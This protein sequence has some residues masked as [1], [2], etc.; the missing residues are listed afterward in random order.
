MQCFRGDLI[1]NLDGRDIGGKPG[2]PR[3]PEPLERTR[4]YALLK[5][6]QD[7]PPEQACVNLYLRARVASTQRIPSTVF[8]Q[9]VRT[10]RADRSTGLVATQ[11][12][13][14]SNEVHRAHLQIALDVSHYGAEEMAASLKR[15][16]TLGREV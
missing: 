4:R 3:I 7:R 13:S 14:A 1:A 2:Q 16:C 6:S 15:R 8:V 9:N 12:S 11:L 10:L 5:V